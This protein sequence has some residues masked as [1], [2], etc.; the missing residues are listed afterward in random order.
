MK[1][2]FGLT[3][4]FYNYLIHDGGANKKSKALTKVCHKNILKFEDYNI[5][6]KATQLKNK[7]YHL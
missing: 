7:I 5:S 2:F 3:A 6:L 4:K 1:E